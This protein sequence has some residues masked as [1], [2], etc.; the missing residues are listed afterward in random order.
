MCWKASS[1]NKLR[2]YGET[3]PSSRPLRPP[4]KRQRKTR[5][6]HGSS[7]LMTRWCWLPASH[8]CLSI[9]SRLMDLR[10][11][12]LPPHVSQ[13]PWTGDKWCLFSSLTAGQVWMRGDICEHFRIR[14]PHIVSFHYEIIPF[15]AK[16]DLSNTAQ[17]Q[18][19]I[20]LN[21]PR[22]F[23]GGFFVWKHWRYHCNR[24]TKI[25]LII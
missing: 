10:L 21:Y 16:T 19:T 11:T 23:S 8:V 17:P 12:P 13:C 5:E 22:E 18:S 6:T 3:V 4:N 9:I 24:N 15:L 1:G 20:L 14:G 2:W 7:F 25:N